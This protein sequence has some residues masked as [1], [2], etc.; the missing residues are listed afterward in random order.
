MGGGT[1]GWR[2]GITTGVAMAGASSIFS[3]RHVHLSSQR[4]TGSKMTICTE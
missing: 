2:R 1:R 4:S 3:R